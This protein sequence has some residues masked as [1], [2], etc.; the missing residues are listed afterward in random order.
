MLCIAYS[1][2]DLKKKHVKQEAHGPRL[3]T[4]KAV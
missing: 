2:S 3:S 4:E 1:V